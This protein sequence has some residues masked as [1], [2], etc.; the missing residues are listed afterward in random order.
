LKE[1]IILSSGGMNIESFDL[2]AD[3]DMI[4]GH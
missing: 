1:P 4:K 3:E 2:Y